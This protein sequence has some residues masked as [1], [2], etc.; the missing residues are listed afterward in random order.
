VK[1]TLKNGDV[2]YIYMDPET[3]LEL[4]QTSLIKREGVERS[5]DTYFGEYKDVEG[6]IFPFAIEVKLPGGQPGPTYTIEK[7]E[8]NAEVADSIFA[9]PAAEAPQS[10][11]TK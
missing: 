7:V 10:Q 3:G 9:M 4:K 8:L 6:L 11:P 2:R 5:I 1:L